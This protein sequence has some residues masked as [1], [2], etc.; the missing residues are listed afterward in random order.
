[1]YYKIIEVHV[2]YT[3][4]EITEVAALW[5]SNEMGWVRASFCTVK[6]VSG[7]HFLG[8]NETLSPQLIQ[9]VSGGGMNLPDEKKKKYFPGKRMW[10]R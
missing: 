4:N 2:V 7:Y 6:P 9:T 5:Q 1:M 3:E 8:K 10:E